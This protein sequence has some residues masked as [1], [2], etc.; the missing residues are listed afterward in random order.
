MMTVMPKINEM[1]KKGSVYAFRSLS[2]TT[3]PVYDKS[4][5]D[6]VALSLMVRANC[7]FKAK[8]D[9]NWTEMS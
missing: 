7:P 2:K 3:S 4:V 6:C 5:H 1:V 8:S 9:Q